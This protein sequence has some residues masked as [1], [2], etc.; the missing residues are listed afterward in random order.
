MQ[1][2]RLAARY[3]KSLLDFA[4]EQNKLQP[5]YQDMLS[6]HGV[7]QDSSEF[8]SLMKSP[9]VKADRKLSIISELFKDKIE[10]ITTSYLNLIVQKGRE[11]FLP[12]IISSFVSLYKKVSNIVDVDLTTAEVLDEQ[13][14]QSLLAKIQQQF[15]G[16]TVDLHTH[17]N[18]DLIGG[19]VLE[20]NNNLFD[21]SIQR[22][23]KDI[24]KQFLENMYIPNIR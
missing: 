23:L 15:Q 5:I 22:D 7:C 1:N 6:L 2:P 21:A 11:F 16:L 14:K 3:A 19:F 4:V 18:P 13:A 20:S 17:V 9:I 8:V 12:E 10:P 24:R